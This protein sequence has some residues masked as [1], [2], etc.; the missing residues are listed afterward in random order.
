[1][2]KEYSEDLL[3]KILQ[4]E[5]TLCEK[6]GALALAGDPKEALNNRQK[7]K[8]NWRARGDLNPGSPAPEAC[9]LPS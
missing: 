8:M 1:M 4:L 9:A 6:T 7:A 3:N 5:L 2:K